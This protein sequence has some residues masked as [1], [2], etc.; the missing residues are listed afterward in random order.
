AADD[1]FGARMRSWFADYDALV[2]PVLTRPPVPIGTWAGKGWVRTMLGV[3]NCPVRWNRF[4]A[5][6]P[7]RLR[8]HAA[9]ARRATRTTRLSEGNPTGRRAIDIRVGLQGLFGGRPGVCRIDVDGLREQ[10]GRM[11]ET[12]SY[13]QLR[14]SR[15][16]RMLAGVCG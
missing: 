4:A 10:A 13:R 1:P 5:R 9:L 15:S 14:R 2:T 8:S 12:A 6:R 3:G 11:T 7:A 16:D